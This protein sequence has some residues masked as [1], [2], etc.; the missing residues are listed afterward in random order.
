MVS[1]SK[2]QLYTILSIL[3]SVE[4]KS[5]RSNTHIRFSDSDED[6]CVKISKKD[7]QRKPGDVVLGFASRSDSES[8]EIFVKP[9]FQGS[10]GEKLLQL[11]SRYVLYLE[12]FLV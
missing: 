9:Q 8:D 11:Q 6:D 3:F 12:I 2:L 5:K 10:S 7:I 4:D 1:I